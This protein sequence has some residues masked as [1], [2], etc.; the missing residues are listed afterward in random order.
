MKKTL[1]IIAAAA[2]FAFPACSA[3]RFLAELNGGY[4]MANDAAFK[5]VYGKGGFLPEVRLQFDLGSSFFLS[6]GAGVVSKKGV[7]PGLLKEAKSRQVFLSLGGG[8]DARLSENLHM[9]VG[10]ALR[11]VSYREEV[12]GDTQKGSRLGW[13]LD[14]D[15]LYSL[16]DAWRAGITAGYTYASDTVE[17]VSF[18][19]GGF[20]IGAAVGFRF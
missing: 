14:A 2:A 15:L 5:E 8:Y 6:A 16:G 17:E 9:R 12:A 4:L 10:P 19:M 3:D 11:L 7:T 20:R 1:L 13:G 18:K